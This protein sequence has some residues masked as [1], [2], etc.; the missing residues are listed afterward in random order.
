MLARLLT[1]LVGPDLAESIL[2][3]L[4][5]QRS[6]R[7]QRSRAG[8]A[9]WLK[10][11]LLAILIQATWT[12]L[13]EHARSIWRG[14]IAPAGWLEVRSAWRGLRRAPGYAVT[15]IGVLA[16]SLTM[17]VLV[18]AVVDG[19][20]LK[21]LPY[22]HG[23]ALVVL[24]QQEPLAGVHRLVEREGVA[25]DAGRQAGVGLRLAHAGVRE[26]RRPDQEAVGREGGRIVF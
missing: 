12:R 26:H 19:V 10:R 22:S 6:R 23:D 2:G 21:P 25:D 13:R 15:T 3:D 4:D 14:A 20:L 17:A 11:A 16:V 9:L 18:F 1:W 24:H 8:A 5:E 7:A